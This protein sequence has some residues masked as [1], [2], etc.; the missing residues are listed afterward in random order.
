MNKMAEDDKVYK[1][2]II[3]LAPTHNAEDVEKIY[4][5][6][7]DEALSEKEYQNSEKYKNKNIAITGGYG[8]GKSSILNTYFRTN[9][10]ENEP[11]KEKVL[12]VSLGSFI[13]ND[14]N[15]DNKEKS[16]E[17]SIL[18]QIIY[19]VSKEEIPFSRITRIDNNYRETISWS[20][21]IAFLA[22]PIITFTMGFFKNAGKYY[23]TI[24]SIIG[25]IIF[26][27]IWFI[28]YY[29][30]NKFNINT[31]HFGINNAKA[32]INNDELSLLNKY[33]DELVYFFK[34]TNKEIIVF[35]DIDRLEECQKIFSKLKEVN[36]IINIAIKNKTIRFIY[37]IGDDVFIDAERKT[38]FFDVIIPIIPYVGTI[39]ARDILAR[40]INEKQNEGIQN[41]HFITIGRFI[42]NSRIAYEIINEYNIFKN[43]IKEDSFK[44][45]L[46]YLIAYK[47]LY[48]S[49]F[50]LL[51]KNK[52]VLSYYLSPEFKDEYLEFIHKENIKRS[53]DQK[54]KL[55]S[56]IKDKIDSRIKS[57]IETVKEKYNIEKNT[58]AIFFDEND[59]YIFSFD[60]LSKNS[61]YIYELRK[62]IYKFKVNNKEI[63][64]NEIFSGDY[65]EKIYG[66]K[67]SEDYLKIKKIEERIKNE[68]NY[69][70]NP[71]DNLYKKIEYIKN[72]KLSKESRFYVEDSTKKSIEELNRFEIILLESGFIN[73]NTKKLILR[74]QNVILSENDDNILTKIIDGQELPLETI[75]DDPKKLIDE[76]NDFSFCNDYTAIPALYNEIFKS[77]NKALYIKAISSNWTEKKFNILKYVGENNNI[78][79]LKFFVD[80]I[81]NIWLK[82]K[83][84]DM[85]ESSELINYYVYQTIKVI[86]C[87]KLSKESEFYSIVEHKTDIIDYLENKYNEIKDKIILF[88][89]T[90]SDDIIMNIKNKKILKVI[91]E[92]KMF[93]KCLNHI[94]TL[95]RVMGLSFTSN[96]IIESI[97]INEEEVINKLLTENITD[98]INWIKSIK[99][100]Q[101][102][103]EESII[104][105]VN[106]NKLS[107]ESFKELMLNESNNFNDI[108]KLDNKYYKTLLEMNETKINGT[109]SNL[110]ALFKYKNNI[111]DEDIANFMTINMKSLDKKIDYNYISEELYQE[112]IRSDKFDSD[113]FSYLNKHLMKNKKCTSIDNIPVDN[114][115]E[116]IVQKKIEIKTSEEYNKVLINNELSFENK[117][118]ILI[119]N[120]YYLKSLNIPT[121]PSDMIIKLLRS[122]ISSQD[123][124]EFMINNKAYISD[125]NKNILFD[126][127]L[128]GKVNIDI[129]EL[130]NILKINSND[131]KKIK[132]Y[133][134]YEKELLTKYDIKTILEQMGG[135]FVKILNKERNIYLD[136]NSDNIVFFNKLKD[137]GLVIRRI[138]KRKKFL[139]SFKDK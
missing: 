2:E 74:K 49:N 58:E 65:E 129:D 112:F 38:K 14:N 115:K 126:E 113:V 4:R 87:Q 66:K 35:E 90:F 19:S 83:L 10:F 5:K 82:L 121:L 72:Y 57:L 76:L 21:I 45:Q 111:L 9:K 102:D 41:I 42:S 8:A 26:L 36:S 54:E 25:V 135:K 94:K 70:I 136:D 123:K 61:L 88:D 22:T 95:S 108:S 7:I 39:T 64:F 91:Y 34:K 137:K 133:L 107:E 118:N 97:T 122:N 131:N 132:F 120:I 52:G 15:S 44:L 11:L 139:I 93:T 28:I 92:N 16:I 20:G 89:I 104:S 46:L 119:D 125:D 68:Y 105:F 98:T 109:L 55:K 33:I 100:T 77:P 130:F 43:N 124:V 85:E 69:Y 37:S 51:Y 62:K 79:I 67:L 56:K 48:P 71:N 24:A 40:E 106:K 86:P 80:D 53:I 6:Y 103:S 31:I 75:I 59:D 99:I 32:E 18:Q 3:S 134:T 63:D 73:E 27:F 78:D 13:E 117:Y 81:N 110:N 47:V 116:L 50:E 60:E 1:K 138:M 12:Y 127:L 30:I 101:D 114:L 96:K 17:I 29:I 23:N 84:L 128:K